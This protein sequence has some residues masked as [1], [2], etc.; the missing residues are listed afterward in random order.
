MPAN[1]NNGKPWRKGTIDKR[2]TAERQIMHYS[3][4]CRWREASCFFVSWGRERRRTLSSTPKLRSGTLS[5][6]PFH[7]RNKTQHKEDKHLLSLVLQPF[8]NLLLYRFHESVS[9]ANT[10]HL[11]YY[12]LIQDKSN[13][14]P[15]CARSHK[16]LLPHCFCFFTHVLT[17]QYWIMQQQVSLE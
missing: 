14:S 1:H 4:D 3:I 12:W 9:F 17:F 8:M 13:V 2:L 11:S 16:P 5:A 6:A 7:K 15:A 10:T